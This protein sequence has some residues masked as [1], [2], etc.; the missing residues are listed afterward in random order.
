M[1]GQADVNVWERE[2]E[3]ERE[4]EKEGT[5]GGQAGASLSLVEDGWTAVLSPEM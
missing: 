1:A 2:K 4:R 3:R 5:Q